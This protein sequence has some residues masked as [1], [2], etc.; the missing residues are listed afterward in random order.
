[1]IDADG[2]FVIE[3]LYSDL[4][5]FSEDLAF[6]C[7]GGHCGY[8]DPSGNWAIEPRFEA[9]FD[10]SEGLAAVREAPARVYGY[11]DHSGRFAITPQFTKAELFHEGAA[12]IEKDGRDG[13]VTRAGLV[14]P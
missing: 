2:K 9:T 10:F 4:G 3:A 11:I 1:M 7:K 13:Y 5:K 8:I 12:R 14:I 6:A